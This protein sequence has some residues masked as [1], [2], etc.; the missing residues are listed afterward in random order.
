MFGKNIGVA[1]KPTNETGTT[2]V[3]DKKSL[4][5]ESGATAFLLYLK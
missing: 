1:F 4:E 5:K 2:L 3:T